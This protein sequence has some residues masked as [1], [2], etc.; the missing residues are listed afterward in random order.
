M[1]PCASR[2]N[3]SGRARPPAS[4][5]LKRPPA[6]ACAR[7]ACVPTVLGRSVYRL[8][9]VSSV[10]ASPSDNRLVGKPMKSQCLRSA[11][12]V[13]PSRRVSRVGSEPFGGSRRPGESHGQ[14]I[15]P[16]ALPV[17]LRLADARVAAEGRGDNSTAVLIR[18]CW[19]CTYFK[20]QTHNMSG[21]CAGSLP[22][23]LVEDRV[24]A[25]RG[26]PLA[27][28]CF[29]FMCRLMRYRPSPAISFACH[30]PWLL[31]DCLRCFR[32]RSIFTVSEGGLIKRGQESMADLQNWLWRHC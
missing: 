31:H 32:G 18:C 12:V 20:S 6:R 23:G 9:R 3:G 19:T 27:P 21:A 22:G 28:V 13:S 30:F 29:V 26:G 1:G 7:V 25:L 2:R 8:D 17:S 24:V 16:A 10:A 5:P 15:C 11:S 14:L 4:A